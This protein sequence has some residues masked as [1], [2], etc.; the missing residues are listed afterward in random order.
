M[1]SEYVFPASVVVLKFVYKLALGRPVSKVEFFR[2]ILNFPV[3]LAFL[4][5]SFSAI[6]L[7]FLQVRGRIPISARDGFAFFLIY[8]VLTA[9]V[10]LMA[11]QSDNEFEI[12]NHGLCIVWM[13]PAYLLAIGLVSLIIAV[14]G[15][16]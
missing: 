3:D 2:A 6:I 13:I 8:I 5:L 4:A 7:S 1:F 11:R 15:A 16:A 12:D 10:T 9:I 14:G